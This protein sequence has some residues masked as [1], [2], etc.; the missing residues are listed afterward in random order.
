MRTSAPLIRL[1]RAICMLGMVG[2]LAA[3]PLQIKRT[4]RNVGLQPKPASLAQL[5]LDATLEV[6][7]FLLGDAKQ[8]PYKSGEMQIPFAS[9]LTLTDDQLR[10]PNLFASFRWSSKLA[11]PVSAEWQ[12]VQTPSSYG[13]DDWEYPA[14]IVAKGAANELPKKAGDPAYFVVDLK[15]IYNLPKEYRLQ[16]PVKAVRR[17]KARAPRATPALNGLRPA[18]Q[19]APALTA[20]R[21]AFTKA[22]ATLDE[23]RTYYVRLVLLNSQ[24]KPVAISSYVPIRSKPPTSVTLYPGSLPAQDYPPQLNLPTVKILEYHPP[25]YFSPDDRSQHFIVLSNCPKMVLDTMHWKVGQ[26]IRLSPKR[27]EGID[28]IGDAAGAA[29]DALS[30]VVNWVSQAWSDIQAGFVDGICGGNNTCKNLAGPALKIGL[31]YVGI[32]PELPNSNE[33]CSM[34]KDY[35]VSYVAAET[36]VS[37]D[38]IRAGV[39]KMA[40]VVNN[41]PGGSGGTFLW[42]DPAFQDQPARIEVEITNTSNKPTDTS[43]LWL[44]YGSTQGD[45]ATY[46]PKIPMWLDTRT[47]MPPLQPGGSLRFPVFL[48]INPETMI[49]HGADRLST[50]EGRRVAVYDVGGKTLYTGQT[51]WMGGQVKE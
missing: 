15:P 34:G 40:D 45:S 47:P 24:R 46:P 36:G 27:D 7:L 49:S 10:A 39:D 19:V 1:L 13:M 44:L 48:T 31:M 9:Q 29:F 50:Y 8:T 43:V 51:N 38:L 18:A 32:P 22:M 4:E 14:G 35:I 16:P 12:V 26:Q 23:H 3:A 41:P 17:S 42:P 30:D 20:K 37:E 11:T 33:L 5:R 21:L 2:S 28:S 25:K 6:G